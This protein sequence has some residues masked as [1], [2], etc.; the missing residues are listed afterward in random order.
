VHHALVKREFL[1]LQDVS[2][3]ASGLS[4]SGGDL[5]QDTSGGELGVQSGVQ[6]AVGLS[7]LE[8]LDDLF[9]LSGHVDRLPVDIS[10]LV[11][12]LD[13]N[14][15]SVVGLVP[16]LEGVGVND[17]DGTLHQGLGA[18]QFVVGRV[19]GD[20]ED[21]DLAGADLGSPGEV[22]GVQ[23]EG[24]ELGVSSPAADLVDA[25]LADL[26]HGRGP[27]EIVLALLAELGAASS[28]LPALVSSFASDTHGC[29]WFVGV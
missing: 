19:V 4:R 16:G 18:D 3:A 2:V 14:L 10:F 25:G 15:D 11:V 13:T 22:P 17:D 29:C 12:L 1:A 26:G 21:T 28:G 8:L 23:S 27:S 20:I 5:G 7:G 24:T 9:R 6:G